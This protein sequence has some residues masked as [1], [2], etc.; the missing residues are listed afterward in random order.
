MSANDRAKQTAA[1]IAEGKKARALLSFGRLRCASFA[2]RAV[3]LSAAA[4]PPQT[5]LETEDVGVSIL[6]N[7]HKQRETIVRSGNTVRGDHMLLFSGPAVD[8]VTLRARSSEFLLPPCVLTPHVFFAPRSCKAW[9]RTLAS[10][11]GTL[12]RWASAPCRTRS[13]WC[14]GWLVVAQTVCNASA[15]VASVA[16]LTRARLA[17]VAGRRDRHAYHRY[18]PYHLRQASLGFLQRRRRAQQRRCATALLLGWLLPRF[19]TT[20]R[21]SAGGTPALVVVVQTASMLAASRRVVFVVVGRRSS[22]HDFD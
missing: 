18:H 2:R 17:M 13:C 8:K 7:L 16:E 6:E 20:R 9:T 19:A 21:G 12:A 14:A 15:L 4:S 11:G 1:R 3:S 10:R 5:L 22:W